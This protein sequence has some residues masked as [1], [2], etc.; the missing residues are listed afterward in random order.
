MRIV[1]SLVLL[2]VMIFVCPNALLGQQQGNQWRS[3][4]HQSV[5]QMQHLSGEE[6]AA[7]HKTPRQFQALLESPSD[8]QLRWAIAAVDDERN[9]VGR[10]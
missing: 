6:L 3:E 1:Q 9:Q 7:F 10:R 8:T 2:S 4:W 5:N